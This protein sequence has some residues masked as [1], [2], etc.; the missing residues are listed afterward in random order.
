MAGVADLADLYKS[1]PMAGIADLY[2]SIPT[3]MR[4][5]MEQV[6]GKESPITEKDFTPRE[7]TYMRRQAEAAS[8]QDEIDEVLARKTLKRWEDE[9]AGS[10]RGVHQM[11]KK[12]PEMYSDPV[13]HE[14]EYD[15]N[16]EEARKDVASFRD[17]TV[18]PV[19]YGDYEENVRLGEH[20]GLFWGSPQRNVYETIRDSF[21]KPGYVVQTS[22]GR[23]VATKL[24]DG[25]VEIKDRYNWD[26]KGEKL[27]V[28]EFLSLVPEMLRSPRA[29]GNVIMRQWGLDNSRDV[30]ITLPKALNT[31]ALPTLPEGFNAG[32]RTR[33]L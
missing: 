14:A 11:N 29:L 31:P 2:K 24:P 5:F 21:T 30:N 33:L 27:T 26:E 18:T 6:V 8:E 13:K 25:T 22:L 10:M 12:W 15:R 28:S 9:K 17:E 7:L 4:L 3:N 16:T 20:K 19:Q 1:I 23:Y 32:G